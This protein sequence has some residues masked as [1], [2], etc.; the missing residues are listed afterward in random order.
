[1]VIVA[2][3]GIRTRF[4]GAY[5]AI[6]DAYFQVVNILTGDLAR[7]TANAAIT[8]KVKAQSAHDPITLLACFA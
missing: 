2:W 3:G 4:I 6:Q 1:M 7:P 8:V 5:L